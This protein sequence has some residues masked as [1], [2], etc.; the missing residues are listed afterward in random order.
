L[1]LTD[2]PILSYYFKGR[3]PLREE[4]V[5]ISSVSAAEFLLV[6]SSERIKPNYYPFR[7][8]GLRMHGHLQWAQMPRQRIRL[9]TDEILVNTTPS[10]GAYA[11]YGSE[12]LSQLI[13]DRDDASFAFC[14]RNLARHQQRVLRARFG[15]LTTHRIRVLP[16]TREIARDI[17]DLLAKFLEHNQPKADFRNTLND[18]LI[19]ATAMNRSATLLTEDRVLEAFATRIHKVVA[20]PIGGSLVLLNFDNTSNPPSRN[21]TESKGYINTRLRQSES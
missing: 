11:L 20:N 15:F 4:R 1:T 13:N 7:T 5:V 9:L 16:L 6:H 19:L 18:L 10:H 2:T 21:K 17:P 14:I 12:A 8:M 3:L